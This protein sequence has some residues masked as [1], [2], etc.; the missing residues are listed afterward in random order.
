[1]CNRR[2]V[3]LARLTVLV[4]VG[5]GVWGVATAAADQTNTVSSTNSVPSTAP[6]TAE[7]SGGHGGFGAGVI[8]GQPTGFTIKYWL[9]EKTAFD[10]GAAWS[11]ESNGYF[12]LYGDFLYHKFDLIPIDRGELPLYFGVGAR[13]AIP[14]H[15]STLAGVRIPV[16]IA[17][18]IPD[19]PLE[20]F[21]EVVPIVDF[22]P[23]TDL[24]WNG[25]VG[26]RYFFR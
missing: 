20:V 8:L 13:V 22:A 4:S 7:K 12:N 19:M 16:G 5:F 21:A 17:Y 9:A 18:E 24:H 15:G 2:K 11:F 26:V 3:W 25:G 10:V 6:A 14:D 1:M 23:S